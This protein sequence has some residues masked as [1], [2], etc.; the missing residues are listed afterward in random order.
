MG[1]PWAEH[2]SWEIVGEASE[3]LGRDVA[4]LLLDAPMEELTATSNAQLA[5]LVQSLVVL[6]AVER[7]G[8]TPFAC[9]G[10]SLGE[11]TALVATG[12]LSFDDV[13]RLVTVRGEAMHRAGEDSP[14]TMAAVLGLGDDD[15]EAACQR[16]EGDAWLANY[17]APGQVVMAGTSDGL[18]RATGIAKQMG[19]RRVL[20]I[21]VSGAFHTPMMGAAR[22]ALRKAIDDAVFRTPEVPLLANVD[23]RVHDDPV[24]WPSLL[25]AQLCSPVR[26]RQILGAL[27]GLG[28]TTIAEIGPGGVL[29]GLLR[30]TEPEIK[31]VSVSEPSHL[32]TLMDAVTTQEASHPANVAADH[33]QGE[34]L[35]VTERVVVSPCAGIFR[36]EESVVAP[37]MGLLPGTSE[38]HPAAATS[39]RLAVG[40]LVGHVGVT[41]VRTPFAGKVS[42][43][44]AASGDRLHPGQPVLWLSS[45]QEAHGE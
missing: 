13:L 32:D 44:L 4:A 40:D 18:A 12:S 3:V 20:P 42:R 43:W 41:E 1:Q 36:P 8:L 11:Y 38:R 39:Q 9:A 23:A 21:P 35:Y 15:A 33:R 16:A 29:T 45:H 22:P 5:T 27:A 26:W 24:E 7:L 10:H 31:A 19:A 30:R 28:S 37:G 2:P 14:G 17:N 34:H 25:S 6:D